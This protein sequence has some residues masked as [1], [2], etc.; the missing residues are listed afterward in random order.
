M[1][2]TLVGIPKNR[3][4]VPS[5]ATIPS[6]RRTTSESTPASSPMARICS[7]EMVVSC[8]RCISSASAKTFRTDSGSCRRDAETDTVGGD[9]AV[10]SDESS[11]AATAIRFCGSESSC[12]SENL[13]AEFA[14]VILCVPR[15]GVDLPLFYDA[16]HQLPPRAAGPPIWPRIER[17]HGIRDVLSTPI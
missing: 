17:T 14:V 13:N 12:A 16:S 6:A 9:V 5:P 8:S 3:F 10:G 7:S 11:G 15:C 4:P 1:R 2:P